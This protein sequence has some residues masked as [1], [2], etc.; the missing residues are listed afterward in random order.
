MNVYRGIVMA[1]Q[2]ITACSM[3]NKLCESEE[4]V[5]VPKRG[6]VG[7][8]RAESRLSQHTVSAMCN[9]VFS[10][11]Y[12]SMRCN[13]VEFWLYRDVCRGY[14]TGCVDGVENPVGKEVDFGGCRLWLIVV[15]FTGLLSDSGSTVNV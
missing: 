12:R 8:K 9:A 15:K 3:A 1:H 6:R 2:N 7:G 5:T 13:R 4:T 14:A 10:G 11:F